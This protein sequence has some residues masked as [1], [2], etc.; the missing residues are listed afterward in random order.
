MGTEDIKLLFGFLILVILLLLSAIISGSEVAFFSLT[1]NDLSRLRKEKT[2]KALS[3]L[4]LTAMPD[5]LLSTILVANNLV[6]VGIIILSA[7][8]SESLLGESMA[9]VTRFIVE[10]VAITFIILLFGEIMPKVYAT[11]NHFA[12]AYNMAVPLSILE[13]A[14]RPG[15]AA[16]MFMTKSVRKRSLSRKK[17]ISMNDLSDALDLT[18]D[19]LEEEKKILKGI[20]NFGNISVSAIMCPRVDVTALDITEGFSRVIPVITESGYSRIPVYSGSFDN[21]KGIL[22]AKDVLPYA[23]SPDSF[24]W[25]SLIRPPYFV[26]E[27]KKINELLKEF[28]VR[29]IHMAVVIDEYGGTSGIVTLE[30]ILE[31]IVGEISDESDVDTPLYRKVD[32]NTYIF[33]GKILL[34]DFYKILSLDRDPFADVKGEAETLAGLVLELTGEIPKRNQTIEYGPYIFTIESSDKR[35][36]KEIRV[37]LKS[38]NAGSPEE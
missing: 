38:D 3:L 14:L 7:F 13:K 29:K 19:K 20:V 33:E 11:R 1:P 10:V 27:T 36:I 23:G 9:P 16:L 21:V 26:P 34:N 18:A 17:K 24:K 15:T 28:Q 30:D 25:Q 5:K 32:E 6:N 8:L 2:R 22:Y 37:N 4:S 12:V 35:R 31:E